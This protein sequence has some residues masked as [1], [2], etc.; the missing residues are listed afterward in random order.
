MK[1]EDRAAA[2]SGALF[3]FSGHD[4]VTL[5]ESGSVS[6]EEVMKSFLE[7]I[8]RV[9]PAVNALVSLRQPDQCLADARRIDGLRSAGKP[10]GPL[11]GLPIAIKDLATTA[12]IRT[13]M[14]SL[15]YADNF[16]AKDS[17]MVAR[18]RAAGAIVVGKSN[19]PEFGLGSHTVN[20]VFGPTRNPWDPE[21]SAGGSSGGAAVAVALRMLPFADG[22]DMMGSL[23]NPAG[24]NNV[25]GFRPSWGLVPN[26]R[27]NEL[28]LHTLSTLGPMAR[29][30]E[31]IALLLDSMAGFVTGAPMSHGVGNVFRDHLRSQ[32]GVDR[33]EGV[34]VGWIGG[35]DGALPMEDGILD[36]CEHGALSLLR[37]LGAEIVPFVPDFSTAKLWESWC[38]LRSWAVAGKNGADYT[39]ASRRDKLNPETIWEIERG[40]ALSASAVHRAGVIRSDWHRYLEEVF[41][42]Y[43]LLALPT[44][45]VWPFPI[46]EGFPKAIGSTA[47]DTYHRWMEVVIPASLAARPTVALP[48]GRGP[49]GTRGAGLPMG[50]QLM[51]RMRGDM[52]VLRIA[53]VYERACPWFFDRPEP[54]A[55]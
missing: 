8:E 6:S 43:D 15:L 17:P 40:M 12:G 23:R 1:A 32:R 16:P 7:R 36:V 52:E 44:A 9:N 2:A 5:L 27:S 39:D 34:R 28:F 24:W 11:Q 18:L 46:A 20:R 4:L 41:A 14:G 31:D 22:S 42:G 25:V 47:M 48:A 55:R 10:V 50:I 21:R 37:E 26:D 45:Q 35:W 51:G 49:A 19:T 53:S 29:N 38:T 3:E 54:A 30:V 13:T 33:L